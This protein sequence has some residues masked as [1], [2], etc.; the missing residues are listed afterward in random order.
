MLEPVSKSGDA[1]ASQLSSNGAAPRRFIESSSLVQ[2]DLA[3][4]PSN[5]TASLKPNSVFKTLVIRVI[6]FVFSCLALM[7]LSPLLVLI[8]VAIRGNSP[9]HAIVVHTRMSRSKKEFRAFSFRCTSLLEGQHAETS[10][11]GILRKRRIEQLP[12][13]F[14]VVRGDLSLASAI[15]MAKRHSQLL[16]K[17]SKPSTDYRL[18]FASKLVANANLY[19]EFTKRALDIFFVMIFAPIIAL[20]VGIIWVLVRLDGGPGFYF[21]E[22]VGRNG[23][24][25]RCWKIR[26]MQVDAE[27]QLEKL[28]AE[29]P[30]TAS[31]WEENYKLSNDPRITTLGRLLRNTSLDELPQF[32]NVIVGDMSL[33]G[34][35]PVV[36]QELANYG[37]GLSFY[38]TGRPGLT[39]VWQ[40]SGRNALPY[41]RRVSMDIEYVEKRSFFRDIKLLALTVFSLSGI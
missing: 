5:S 29:C 11:G 16:R 39:G 7:I 25:F 22:R 24:L 12:L 30:K 19:S 14:N 37:R 10:V 13:L 18:T 9:G 15:A 4:R 41:D 35:R 6:D 32:F 27:A 20:V 21:Q 2:A 34:P 8:S 3:E 28:I 40:V 38:L 33:V 1:H 31:E 26:T 17:P 36:S 23:K